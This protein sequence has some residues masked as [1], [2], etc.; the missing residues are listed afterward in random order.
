MPGTGAYFVSLISH[1]PGG[2]IIPLLGWEWHSENLT[3]LRLHDQEGQNQ[4]C[5]PVVL[6]SEDFPPAPFHPAPSAYL[7]VH[8]A[9]PLSH[10]RLNAHT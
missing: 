10:P 4:A 1:S 3:C 2:F 5:L 6:Q 8:L 9:W 7:V